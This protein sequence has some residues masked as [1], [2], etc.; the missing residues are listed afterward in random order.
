MKLI[1]WTV[2]PKTIWFWQKNYSFALILSVWYAFQAKE[3]YFG[4]QMDI[5]IFVYPYRGDGF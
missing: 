4:N 1:N 3:E 5:S 2:L